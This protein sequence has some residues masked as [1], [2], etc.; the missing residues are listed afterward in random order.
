MNVKKMCIMGL[1]ISLITVCT[2]YIKVPITVGYLNLGDALIMMFSACVS[3]SSMLV[4]I[5]GV[6][7]A[8]ADVFLGYSQY[9]IFTLI[10]KSIE[11]YVVYFGL[12]HIKSPAVVFLIAGLVMA[13]GYG[14]VDAILASNINL[15]VPQF[16]V[17]SIQ[18]IASAIVAMLCYPYVKKIIK[19]I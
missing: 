9:A 7:S 1:M 18:G 12:K 13:F 6:S 17:N 19:G 5:G 10:I 3:T 2:M 15:F 8:L 14:V 4:L 11:A 16:L